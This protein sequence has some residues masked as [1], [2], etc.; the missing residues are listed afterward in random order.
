MFSSF[1]WIMLLNLSLTIYFFSFN[2]FWCGL[3]H[4]A[5][6]IFSFL[7]LPSRGP[8]FHLVFKWSRDSNPHPRTMGQIVSPRRSPLDQG[9]SLTIY[10][11]DMWNVLS[12]NFLS[13][14]NINAWIL[15]RNKVKLQLFYLCL[16]PK[17]NLQIYATIKFLFITILLAIKQYFL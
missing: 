2:S 1:F 16:F 11:F 5:A 12:L 15:P 14:S 6:V 10:F 17:N 9:D 3:P 8:S 7:F 13:C 4:L